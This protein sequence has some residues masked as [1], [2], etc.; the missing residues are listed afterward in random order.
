MLFIAFSLLI[1]FIEQEAHDFID[2]FN[3]ETKK[4]LSKDQKIEEEI[5][6]LEKNNIMWLLVS[7]V[8]NTFGNSVNMTR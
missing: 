1:E 6:K 2:N 8:K 4:I 5:K 3:F 7:M